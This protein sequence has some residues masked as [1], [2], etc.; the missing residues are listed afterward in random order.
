MKQ[1]QNDMKNLIKVTEVQSKKEL[2]K[3]KRELEEHK[4]IESIF[5]VWYYKNFLTPGALK[6]EW[7][8]TRELKNYLILRQGKRHTRRL[9]EQLRSIE[10]VKSNTKTIESITISVEWKKSS[11][12][13]SNPTATATV[14]FTDHTRAHY[15]SRS[16]GGCG[17][18]KES[19][20][21]SEALNLCGPLLKEMYT[22]K[23]KPCNVRKGNSSVFGY[24]SGYG[25]TPNFEGG[26]GVS[27]YYDI[28]KKLKM[29]FKGIT[30]GKAFD[31]YQV[32]RK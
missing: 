20:A 18:D 29:N 9:D 23:N 12:W 16:V 27:C 15:S 32:T 17:Y 7:K 14:N 5:D 13:G 26:V 24:G 11:M 10:A 22:I 2:S 30:S 4:T 1:K 28:F 6:K 31:V 25:I 3:F 19:T 8:S 21:I